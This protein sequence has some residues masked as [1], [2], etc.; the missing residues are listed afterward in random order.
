MSIWLKASIQRINMHGDN[1]F[2]CLIASC[3][4][5]KT[6]GNIINHN[7]VRDW[8]Y[9]FQ[10]PLIPYYIETH[11]LETLRDEI[12]FQSIISLFHV[13]FYSYLWCFTSINFIF[14]H[15]LMSKKNIIMNWY[16]WNEC[17]LKGNINLSSKGLSLLTAALEV[18]L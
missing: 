3:A 4:S 12:P 18:I 5:E 16:A 13:E 7:Q 2:P 8:Q 6:I 15:D 11:F 17:T 1:G 9:T 14:A 10:N